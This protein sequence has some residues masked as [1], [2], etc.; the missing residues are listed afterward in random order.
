[1]PLV[2]GLDL[3]T[4]GV[5]PE[6]DS[7]IEIGA[8]LWDTSLGLPMKLISHFLHDPTGP[9]SSPEAVEVHGI[10]QKMLEEHGTSP[11]LALC[12]LDMLM[13]R[14]TYLVGHNIRDFDSLFLK[15]AFQKYGL[16]W[17]EIPMIDT[18][19]DLPYSPKIQSRS[20]T[21]LGAVHGFLNP[22]PHRA[23]T[24]VLSCLK[25]LNSYPFNEVERYAKSP[26]LHLV[27]DVTF[28]RKNDAKALGYRWNPEHKTWEKR[29]K[30]FQLDE[31]MKKATFSVRVMEQDQLRL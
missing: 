16:A 3:E 27:A 29:V 30:E 26:S 5:N 7:I 31:E 24:D 22:F 20:L 28:L 18:M 17:R 23:V 25:L 21:Y 12:D 10:T 14:A 4:T 6:M 1:M 15:K 13:T 11:V 9:Q 8:V 19:T 2:L